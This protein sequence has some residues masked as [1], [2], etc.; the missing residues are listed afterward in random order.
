MTTSNKD[1]VEDLTKI[2]M[3]RLVRNV[4]NSKDKTRVIKMLNRTKPSDTRLMLWLLANTCN[5]L[6]K[7]AYLDA[8]VKRR[9]GT[10]YFY[11]LITYA[12]EGIEDERQWGLR[13][14]T[15]SKR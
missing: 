8:K 3:Y 12:Y 5:N 14:P 11:E 7:L 9:W 1:T 2:N 4:V 13:Y 10:D 6:N 15:K